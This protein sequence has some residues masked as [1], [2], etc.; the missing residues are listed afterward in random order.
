MNLSR[1]INIK[2]SFLRELHALPTGLG[3]QI[4]EKIKHLAQNPIP[5][6]HTKKKLNKWSDVYRLRVGDFRV[7]YSFGS[8]WIR[9]LSIRPRKNAYQRNIT[10]EEPTVI[11]TGIDPEIVEDEEIAD[12]VD[13]RWMEMTNSSEKPLPF[14][15]TAEWLLQLSIPE[16]FYN[17]LIQFKTEE[18]LLMSDIPEVWIERIVDNLFPRPIR[19]IMQQ[20]DLALFDTNDLVRYKDGDLMGFLLR[21]DADQERLVDWALQGPALIKGGPGTGKS[22]VALYRVRS[23]L[24]HLQ[25]R[26]EN[27]KILFSTH[28]HALAKFSGQLLEQLLKE[29]KQDVRVEAADDLALQIVRSHH[30]IGNIADRKQLKSVIEEI[31]DDDLLQKFRIDFLLDE[32]E[33]VIEGRDL[34]TLASYLEANRTGRGQA[35]SKG[36]KGRIWHFYQ[37]LCD[38]LASMGVHTASRIRC[39]AHELVIK[40]QFKEKYD[41]VIIDEAQDLTPITLALLVELTKDGRG[42]YITADSSQSIYFRGF[43]WS[44]VHEKLKFRGKAIILKRNYRTTREISEV[45]VNFLL[46]SG[47]GDPESLKYRSSQNGPQP[48][49]L[50]YRDRAEQCQW[51][52][53]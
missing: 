27:V 15:I 41:A 38:K 30:A 1:D 24:E 29:K 8:N 34:K 22:T 39:M 32:I 26:G 19:E 11:V 20:P 23:I 44:E 49:L 18:D 48:L 2:P 46:K 16:Q 50:Q 35:L 3:D 45:A 31:I 21:L 43:S 51:G 53:V 6:G 12:G 17:K 14:D 25:R 4:W 40:G 33:W 7:F 5:D 36:Y 42:I 37:C 52:L 10:Y 9:L 13:Q 47:C 28:T